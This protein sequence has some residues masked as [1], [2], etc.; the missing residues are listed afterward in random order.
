MTFF[1]GLERT[2]ISRTNYKALS[3]QSKASNKRTDRKFY[4]IGLLQVERYQEI[5]WGDRRNLRDLNR[6]PAGLTESPEPG[7]GGQSKG[8]RASLGDMRRPKS[9]RQNSSNQSQGGQD[10]ASEHHGN[11]SQNDQN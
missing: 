1:Y 3:S 7:Q 6:T 5:M 10:Q 11:K 4:Q 9:A 8:G 2:W